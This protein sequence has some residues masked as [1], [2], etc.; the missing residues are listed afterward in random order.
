MNLAVIPLISGVFEDSTLQKPWIGPAE[1]KQLNQPVDGEYQ[2]TAGFTYAAYNSAWRNNTQAPFTTATYALLPVVNTTFMPE[3][4]TWDTDTTQYQASLRCETAQTEISNTDDRG[5]SIE[6]TTLNGNFSHYLCD[7][8]VQYQDERNDS[9]PYCDQYTTFL[10]PWTSIAYQISD[11][12]WGRN[13][14]FSRA[15]QTYLFGWASGANPAWDL[16]PNTSPSPRNLTALFCTTSYHSRPVTATYTMPSGA[17]DSITWFDDTAPFTGIDYFE[18]AVN[19]LFYPALPIQYRSS[20][21][22]TATLGYPPQYLPNVDRHLVSRFGGRPAVV[23]NLGRQMGVSSYPWES[24]SSIYMDNVY[25]ISWFVLANTT[26]DNLADLLKP[27]T[28]MEKYELALQEWFALAVAIELVDQSGAGKPLKITRLRHAKGFKV[29]IRWARG[30]E[31]GV[32]AVIIM[33]T[34]LAVVIPKR[35]CNLDGEPNTLAAALRLLHR[36]TDLCGVMQDAEFFTP[37]QIMDM[38]EQGDRCFKLELEVGHGPKILVVAATEQQEDFVAPQAAGNAKPYTETQLRQRSIFGLGLLLV[39]AA[40]T[41]LLTAAFVFSTLYDG[42][43]G[44]FPGAA[45]KCSLTV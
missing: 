41:A 35:V 4:E 30:A 17:V 43:F 40:V 26:R 14:S 20:D 16:N 3:P 18:D 45:V 12:D 11:T 32:V 2:L 29:A 1:Q 42:K 13:S 23:G 6:I 44:K 15:E 38:L 27:D 22:K 33:A 28:L 8:R 7:L 9:S 39:F 5:I 31:A 21:N 10:T 24:N 25:G 34:I 19:G 36:S 37:A